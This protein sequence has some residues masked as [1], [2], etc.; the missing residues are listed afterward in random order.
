MASR[1][2][3]G[4]KRDNRTSNEIYVTP[5]YF[6]TLQIAV[7]AGRAFSEADGPETER[8][9][10]VNHAFARKFY[11]NSDPV[12]H[13][14]NG[15]MRIVG[16]AGDMVISSA[17][18]LNFG[19]EPLTSEEIIYVPAAQMDDAKLLS[20]VHEFFQ[21]SWIVRTTGP[22]A[23]LTGQMQRALA[24]VDPNLPFSGFYDMRDLM[25]ATLAMQRIE[26]ALLVA[27][28]SL[29]LLLSAV[30]IFALVANLVA[31]RTREIGIRLALGSTIARAMV[32]VGRAGLA[33][34]TLGLLLGLVL[35]AGALRA[36]RSVLFG[37]GAYD[38]PTIAAVVL[39]LAVVAFAATVLPVLRISSI[40]PAA[41]L[42]EE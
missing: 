4:R 2:A 3:T 20:M 6:D 14:L 21:P 10:I 36:L 7:L 25:A 22:V 40:D 35:C 23:G 31:Q 30:G 9:V 8:V 32:D 11:Q 1:S 24:S 16:V 34:S 38:L 28:A 18:Q 12:G 15:N 13:Y 39:T 42:R 26:V 29:A 17:G 33:A 37:V 5:R 41:T 19:S 27:M